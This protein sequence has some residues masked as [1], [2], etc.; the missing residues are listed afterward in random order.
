MQRLSEEPI[1]FAALTESVR[2]TDSG[3]VV[4]FLGTVR[5]M[6]NGRRTTALE[7]EA[8]G[9]MAESKLAE[10]EAEAEHPAYEGGV[11]PGFCAGD[12]GEESGNAEQQNR[13]QMQRREG[14][15]GSQAPEKGAGKR[16]RGEKG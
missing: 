16:A 2:S 7:Y 13:K 9:P 10:I 1:D 15:S 5:E 14:Q 6:T 11:L 12:E 3:A 4:L 8:F